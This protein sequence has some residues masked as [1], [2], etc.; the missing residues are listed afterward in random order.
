MTGRLRRL[1]VRLWPLIGLL[2][3]V[4]ATSQIALL[5]GELLQRKVEQALIY[6]LLVVAL[7]IF[8][9]NSGVFSFGTIAFMA[10]GAYT[11]ALLTIPRETKSEI[12]SQLP[13]GIA[14]AQWPSTAGI[15]FGG[16][17]AALFALV[18]SLPLMRLSGIAASLATFAVL[19]IVNVV[20]NNWTAITNGTSG[21]AGIPVVTTVNEALAW[22]LVAIVAAYV[23]QT[24]RYGLRL[25]ASRED[26][27]AARSVG[28]GVHGERRLGFVVSAFFAGIAGGLFA[29]FIGSFNAAAFYLDTTFLTVV[30]LVVGGV[31]SLAGAVLGSV[32]ISFVSEI[33]LKFENG[34][35]VGST[36]IPGRSGLREVILAVIML[37]VLVLRP[38]GLTD[39][40][41]LRWPFSSSGF[42]LFG[43]QAAPA[44]SEPALDSPEKV[45]VT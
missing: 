11:T 37:A 9:G 3:I 39:G 18:L 24:S 27:R 42:H 2:L 28:V 35:N 29:Q 41:E 4:T 10:I 38:R 31:T 14:H 13:K 32:F 22:T 1:F 16:V 36:H 26:E 33:L 45:E 43:R 7:Y 25:R 12:L 19:I 20:G 34:F 15:V 30:M 23:I 17:L 5:G 21:L 6:L 40:R 44:R 8:T